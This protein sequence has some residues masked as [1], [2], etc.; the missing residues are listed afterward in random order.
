[1]ILKAIGNPW[2]GAIMVRHPQG[3]GVKIDPKNSGYNLFWDCESILLI[4]LKERNT[5]V[6]GTCYASLLH[7][8]RLEIKAKRR[9]KLARGVPL[10]QDNTLVC[11]FT[12]IDQPPYSPDIVPR[13]NFYFQL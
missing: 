5:T 12:E 6:N 1:M 8:L 9:R 3:K 7:R 2:S 11:G 10:L 4:D 13:D